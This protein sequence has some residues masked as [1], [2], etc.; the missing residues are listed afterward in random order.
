[1][2]IAELAKRG[3]ADLPQ[4]EDKQTLRSILAIVALWKG[5]RVYARLLLDFGR[6]S[7][8]TRQRNIRVIR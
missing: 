3:L 5:T 2:A 7:V 6:E 8:G 4:V 1:M